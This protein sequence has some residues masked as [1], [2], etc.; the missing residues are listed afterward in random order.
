MKANSSSQLVS[1][2]HGWIVGDLIK[3]VKV[4]ANVGFNA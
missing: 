4:M 2:I 3:V 1:M